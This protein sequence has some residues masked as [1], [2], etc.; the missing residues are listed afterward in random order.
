[1]T[2]DAMITSSSG[3]GANTR[4]FAADIEK[5]SI[6]NVIANRDAMKLFLHI[7][8]NFRTF[9]DPIANLKPIVIA[10]SDFSKNAN[11]LPVFRIN[12][13]FF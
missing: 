2:P 12:N 9:M 11:M 3:C 8:P 4:I 5:L 7:S 1:M 10:H 6:I 13:N